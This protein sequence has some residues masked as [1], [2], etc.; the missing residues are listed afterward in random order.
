MV[1]NLWSSSEPILLILSTTFPLRPFIP[2]LSPFCP[3]WRKQF[4]GKIVMHLDNLDSR[5]KVMLLR[6]CKWKTQG[7]RTPQSS[8]PLSVSAFPHLFHHLPYLFTQFLCPYMSSIC[9]IYCSHTFFLPFT[10]PFLDDFHR[11][12]LILM[13]P[14]RDKIAQ[15]LCLVKAQGYK[16]LSPMHW[17]QLDQE[18]INQPRPKKMQF[19]TSSLGNRSCQNRL[20]LR[21]ERYG[22]SRQ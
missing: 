20:F 12:S 19:R 13:F 22:K 6:N 17:L 18:P 5:N 14:K 9:M 16:Y 1:L 10:L 4:I 11:K 8:H 7:W 15:K 3:I 2:Y 21:Q